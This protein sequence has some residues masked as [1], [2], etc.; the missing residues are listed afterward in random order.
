[1]GTLAIVRALLRNIQSEA[2]PVYRATLGR[3]KRPAFNAGRWYNVLLF[4]L[5]ASFGI[6]T[7]LRQQFGFQFVAYR[8]EVLYGVMVVGISL[9]SLSWTVPLAALAGQGIIKERIAQTWD[10]LRAIPMPP[11]TILLAKGAAAIRRVWGIAISMAILT[12]FMGAIVGGALIYGQG[13][14]QPVL[15]FVFTILGIAA[16]IVE[17]FQEVALAAVI[18]LAAALQTDSR[19]MATLLGLIGGVLIRLVPL[20]VV[21]ALVPFPAVADPNLALIL[22]PAFLFIGWFLLNAFIGSALLLAA[23]PG[24]PALLI[25]CGLALVRELLTRALLAWAVRRDAS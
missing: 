10:V 9:L 25:V 6:L 11:E 2:N 19:R 8:A 12:A 20:F 14:A 3:V 22:S 23:M 16:V 18:G 5:L 7:F 15:G 4:L 21:L 13:S 1:V 24:L 17:R